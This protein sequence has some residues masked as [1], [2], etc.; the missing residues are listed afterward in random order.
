MSDEKN[1]NRVAF[2]IVFNGAYEADAEAIRYLNRYEPRDRRTMIKEAFIKFMRG[3]IEAASGPK[4]PTGYTAHADYNPYPGQAQ[5][6]RQVPVKAAD[7]IMVEK[8]P[9]TPEEIDAILSGNF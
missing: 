1:I 5:P 7:L 9:K 8:K 4:Q 3:E 2:S 6:Q